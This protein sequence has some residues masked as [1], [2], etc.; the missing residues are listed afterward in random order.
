MLQLLWTIISAFM[1][2][3]LATLQNTRIPWTNQAYSMEQHFL[4]H[5]ARI[6]IEFLGVKYTL[7]SLLFHC[8]ITVNI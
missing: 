5:G 4:T 7:I 2:P 1:F 3:S 8:E 6:D